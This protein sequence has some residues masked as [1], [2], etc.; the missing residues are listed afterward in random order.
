DEIKDYETDLKINPT[1]PLARG[2]ISISEVKIAIAILCIFELGLLTAL[3]PLFAITHLLAM[4]YS[5]AMYL[6]FFVGKL[7]RPLLTTYAV[8][9]T[10]VSVLI[11]ST[12]SS[13]V[14]GV[15]FWKF[16]SHVWLL[17]LANWAYFNLFEFARKTFAP[18]EER[19]GV[20][21]YSKIFSIRGAVM[22]SLSQALIPIVL[23]SQVAGADFTK[24]D[25]LIL[26]GLLILVVAPAFA[27][28]LRPRIFAAKMFRNMVGLYL[29]CGYLGLAWIL[30]S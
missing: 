10:L 27:F 13:V 8:L 16:S 18:L 29:I 7:I 3:S 9:H 14:T 22:L 30:G 2:L 23:V 12:I 28:S 11:G 15:P 26:W 21:S 1:R 4:G 19:D 5:F 6:E 17:L 24:S 20:E 25:N